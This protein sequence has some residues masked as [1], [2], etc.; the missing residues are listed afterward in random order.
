MLEYYFCQLPGLSIH[1]TLHKVARN[2]I[3]YKSKQL[4]PLWKHPTINASSTFAIPYPDIWICCICFTFIFSYHPCFLI[5][6]TL[7]ADIETIIMHKL[8]WE[9]TLKFVYRRWKCSITEQHTGLSKHFDVFIMWRDGWASHWFCLHHK[10][11][12]IQT[13]IMI[14]C[15]LFVAFAWMPAAFSL[16]KC[17]MAVTVSITN[18]VQLFVFIF[19]D[20]L[21]GLTS[22]LI[23]SIF[24]KQD[25]FSCSF[26]QR[27]FFWFLLSNKTL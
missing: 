17:N 8:F 26:Y 7:L 4:Y 22:C 24:P 2:S 27:F 19:C 5:T 13:H 10:P 16:D 25:V 15:L 1:P 20:Q 11:A 3:F 6:P 21:S 9:P 14:I 18:K 23:C 12:S